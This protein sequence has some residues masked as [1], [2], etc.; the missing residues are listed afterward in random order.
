MNIR[1]AAATALITAAALS[2]V[3]LG[4]ASASAATTGHAGQA[5][6]PAGTV[7][8]AVFDPQTKDFLLEAG[9]EVITVV[10]PLQ[11][12]ARAAAAS[13]QAVRPDINSTACDGRNDLFQV[14]SAVD[15]E[16]CYANAGAISVSIPQVYEV[17]SGANHGS[18]D[19]YY[20]GGYYG[21][22][23][24]YWTPIDFNYVDLAY[25]DIYSA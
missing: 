14:Y 9:G 10:P 13:A 7:E 25:I 11:G 12:A 23:I 8:H 17:Y 22:A 16:L 18:I 6:V 19:W 3:T 21:S 15:G 24:G 20:Q 5:T 2:G 1:R 4:A